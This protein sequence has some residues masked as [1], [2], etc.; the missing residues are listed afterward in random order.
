MSISTISFNNASRAQIQRV[1]AELRDALVESSTNRHADVGRTLGRLTANAVTL[2]SQETSLDRLLQSNVLVT[3]RLTLADDAAEGVFKTAEAFQNQL[4]TGLGSGDFLTSA[5]QMARSGIDQL[6][7][8]LNLSVGGQYIFAGTHTDMR[9]INDFAAG[10]PSPQKVVSDHFDA[11]LTAAGKTREN[12]TGEEIGRYFGAGFDTGEVDAEGAPV[13][14]RFDDLFEGEGWATFSSA[15][16]EP[17]TSRIS[18]SETIETSVSANAKAFRDLMAGYAMV[19]LASAD[20]GEGARS[21]IASAA[22]AKIG[23]GVSG[24]TAMRADMGNR[25][26]R[27]ESA[28]T[29]LKQQMDIVSAS[30]ASLEEVDLVE[31]ANR[32]ATLQTQLEASY[33]VTGLIREIN[34]LDYL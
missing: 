30:L 19:D 2:R 32:V 24:L 9:P 15:S 6:A 3:Q 13:L 14:M 21:A 8:S 22:S 10:D 20:M 31:A 7:S 16:D 1:Q 17:I 5:K 34:I 26:A 12:V 4:I 27:V 28:E 33:R 18:K 29:A 11:F 25:M 23:A